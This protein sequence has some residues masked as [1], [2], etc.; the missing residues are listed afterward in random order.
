MWVVKSA[1]LLIWAA[2]AMLLSPA[3]ALPVTLQQMRVRPPRQ[4][5][6][7]GPSSSGFWILVVFGFS[8]GFVYLASD[9]ACSAHGHMAAGGTT[10]S[11]TWLLAHML[12][13]TTFWH[14]TVHLVCLIG[15]EFFLCMIWVARAIFGSVLSRH[16]VEKMVW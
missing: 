6:P 14:M 10:Y 15:L 3:F 9:V 1:I 4:G 12:A 8:F 11:S 7:Y 5:R 2:F 13:S 16:L